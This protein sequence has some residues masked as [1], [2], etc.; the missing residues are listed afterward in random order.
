MTE[1]TKPRVI[2]LTRTEQWD[3]HASFEESTNP[4]TPD[5]QLEDVTDEIFGAAT[6]LGGLQ[7]LC[8]E[9]FSLFDTL[10]CFEIC[11]AKND[12]RFHRKEALTPTKARQNG[13]LI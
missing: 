7:M 9:E 8:K 10:A 2:Q 11:D 4:I 13:I 1:E 5:D 12:V 6:S 3:V